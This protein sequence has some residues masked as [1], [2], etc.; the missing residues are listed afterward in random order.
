MARSKRTQRQ[1][2]NKKADQFDYV[3]DKKVESKL[4]E[5][6]FMPSSLETIDRAMIRFVDEDLNLFTN[7]N[8]GF[9]KVPVLWVTAERAYQIKHNKDLRDKEETLILP[10][11]TVNRASVT[12]EPSYKGTVFANLYPVDDPKGGTITIARQI[13]QKKTAEFQNAMANRKYGAD[14]NV[15]S[16]MKN[17]NKRNMSAAKT[18]YETISI[19]IPTWIKVMYEVSIRTEYQQQLNELIRPFLTIPGNSRTPRRIEAEGHYYEVFIDGG[20]ANNSN[21]SNLGMEQR[22][23]ETKINIEVLGY[24]IGEGENQEKPKIV[25]RENAVEYKIGRERTIV[26]DIPENIKDGFYRE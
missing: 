15:D 5:I 6:E 7:T 14:S 9:K 10:L 2:Q 11:I 22:N 18:V 13:N 3:G 24:L 8:E 17:T 19:P 16:K 23:Y 1:I 21:K 20:F 4:Q 26:G 25:R 12:K